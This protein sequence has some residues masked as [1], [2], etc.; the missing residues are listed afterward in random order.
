MNWT[1]AVHHLRTVAATCAD[2]AT[3][4]ASIFPLRVG[5]LWVA[6]DLLGGQR[7]LDE[8][9]VALTVDI[10]EV[11]WLTEPNGARHWAAAARLPQ[12]PAA[13]YWRSA[14]APVWNHVLERPVLV[15]SAEDGVREDVLDAIADGSARAL[16]PAAPPAAE[17]TARLA[18]E[19]A[20]SLRALR[21]RTAEYERRRWK[22]GKV[23]PVSDALWQA[24]AGYL[25]LLGATDPH[26]L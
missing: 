13:V 24:S 4:P 11:P 12:T 6:G 23:E 20:L 14:H 21:E 9:T 5:G 3:R 17:V 26:R 1:R 25:D 2:M 15:W 16:R 8:I 22:P 7:E 18:D 19:L 10:D